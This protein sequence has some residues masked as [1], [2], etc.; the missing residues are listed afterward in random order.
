MTSTKIEKVIVELERLVADGKTYWEGR[1]DKFKQ[2]L[3]DRAED[4]SYHN[5]TGRR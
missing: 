3:K 4:G 5:D 1:L 2:I